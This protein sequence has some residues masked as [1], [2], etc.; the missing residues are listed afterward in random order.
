MA[1]SPPAELQPSTDDV[2]R[3]VAHQ[4]PHL[5]HLSVA[6]GPHGWDNLM[7]RLGP[8]LAVRIPRRAV[9]VPLAAHEHRW[10]PTIAQRLPC[11]VPTPVH[12]GRPDEGL[13]WAWSI[14]PWLP[15]TPAHRHPLVPRATGTLAAVFRALHE[16][17]PYDAPTNPYRGV[18]L[19]GVVERT[20]DT[21]D[22]LDS[23]VDTR[24][25]RRVLSKGVRAHRH[26]GPP[27]WIHG[28]P[29]P[30]NVLAGN[31][32]QLAAL[33]DWGDLAAGDPATDLAAL[34]MLFDPVHH[35]GFWAAYGTARKAL[36]T[37]SRAWAVRFGAMLLKIGTEPSSPHPGYAEVGRRTLARVLASDRG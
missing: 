21:L 8:L 24:A 16:P 27:V 28:D 20:H 31:D 7:F 22:S 15:G 29:H 23:E 18:P 2:R 4:A 12:L 35:E 30:A 9:A 14:V 36:R 10:L 34:W 26:V 13:P 25:L 32:G 6:R 3:W 17:A 5:A 37:R 11:P 1:T 19:V 33:I